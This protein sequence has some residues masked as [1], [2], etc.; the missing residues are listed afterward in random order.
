M[1]NIRINS[2]TS[3]GFKLVDFSM[4]NS[5]VITLKCPRDLH[6][7]SAHPEQPLRWNFS[8]NS[9]INGS[10]SVGFAMFDNK[11]IM[12]GV[13]K[14]IVLK[15][16][17]VRGY[18]DSLILKVK[19]INP[20]STLDIP[21]GTN[22]INI[23][24]MS[25]EFSDLMAEKKANGVVSAPIDIEVYVGGKFKPY[26]EEQATSRGISVV[27]SSHK[28]GCKFYERDYVSSSLNAGNW[29]DCSL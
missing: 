11:G 17:R 14:S 22:F 6:L 8:I 2:E 5:G 12:N 27:E 21:Y 15:N 18:L 25:K 26:S 24:F 28:D 4:I 20:D 7:D 13:Y 1:Y 19:L 9:F 29:I 23:K 10:E 3:D 16:N